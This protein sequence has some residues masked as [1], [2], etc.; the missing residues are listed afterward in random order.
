MARHPITATD[1]LDV[2]AA[3]VVAALTIGPP[4]V[5]LILYREG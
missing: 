4:L 3:L 1:V 2:M 5:A